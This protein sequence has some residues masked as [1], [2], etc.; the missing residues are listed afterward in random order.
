MSLCMNVLAN[1]VFLVLAIRN[2]GFPM[3]ALFSA[4]IFLVSFIMNYCGFPLALQSS[5][6]PPAPYVSLS[7]ENFSVDSF[8]CNNVKEGSSQFLIILPLFSFCNYDSIKNVL[9]N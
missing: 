8:F 9:M 7:T 2:E 1:T 3:L 4:N 5:L 6:N